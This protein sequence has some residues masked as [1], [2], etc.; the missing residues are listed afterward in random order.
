MGEYGIS[1]PVRRT[2]DPRLL[3]G[4]GRFVDDVRFADMAFGYVLRSP[5]AHAD[6]RKLD[7]SAAAKAPGV[8]AVLTSADYEADGCGEIP[9]GRPAARNSEGVELFTTPRLPL[10]TDRVRHVGDPIAFVV[11]ETIA[12]AKDASELIVVDY[13]LLPASTS[14]ADAMK[15]DTPAIWPDCPN[16]LGMLHELGDKDATG[17]AFAN[18]AHTV[19]QEL[20]VNR[21]S[22]NSMEP[23]GTVACYDAKEDFC[24]IYIPTQSAFSARRQYAGA[25]FHE[26]E[27]HYRV[28]TGDMGGSFGMKNHMYPDQILTIWASKKLGRP[29]KWISERSEALMS[30][31][32]GRDNVVEAGLALDSDGKILA[33][34]VQI[35]GS[36]GAYTSS[37][38]YGPLT[39]NLGTLAGPYTIENAYVRIQAVF[40]NNNPTSAYRGAGRPEAAYIIERLVDLAARELKIDATELRRR[41]MIPPDAFPYKTA[42][43]FTY[44]SGDFANI[45]DQAVQVSGYGKFE[46]RRAE[47]RKR[48]KYR[49]LGVSYTIERAAG[50]SLEHAEIRFDPSGTATVLVGTTNHGQGHQTIYTQLACERFGLTPDQV[51]VVEGDT[52]AMAFGHGTGGS[53]VS[54]MGMSALS[55]AAD[56]VIEKGLKIA[57]HVLEAAPADIEFFE[58]TYTVAGTDKSLAFDEIIKI[59]FTPAELPDDMEPGLFENGTYRSHVPNFPNGCHICEIEIDEETGKPAL[60]SYVVVDDFGTVL[61]PLLLDGQVHGGIA[62]GA[63]QA[64][65]ENVAYDPDSGQLLSGS[66]MDYTMPR[67]DD[68]CAIEIKSHP[69]PTATNPFGVKGAG[70]AGT[71]GSLPAV[72][73]AVVDALSPLGVKHIAMPA[74]AEVIWR[75]MQDADA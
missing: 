33:L 69:V 22:A 15:P 65:M 20:V 53:R 7:V 49:G 38:G 16:N 27:N 6:I 2:E 5:H 43:T 14:T 60:V 73:N 31:N 51:R 1:Q 45:L 46:E 21:V 3:R 25:I 26:P 35:T 37:G 39:N 56:K 72:S 70:E 61:N 40:T 57:S 63:G 10:A 71:V 52:G 74:T 19:H 50:P 48:G 62:Q 44:D 28:V 17:A 9:V 36:V 54:T 64:L 67:G 12:Q 47:A 23:R 13:E 11:A 66:F 29:V 18:A 24:T 59:A 55:I 58:G 75:A 4:A 68:F 42:I 32:H 30:D 41:N 34:R 8:L